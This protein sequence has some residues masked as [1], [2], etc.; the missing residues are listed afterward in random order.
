MHHPVSSDCAF[1]GISQ[2]SASWQGR[3]NSEE[4]IWK[5]DQ[6]V[7]VQ[8]SV[9]EKMEWPRY[10]LLSYGSPHRP[11]REAAN[12]YS[13]HAMVERLVNEVRHSIPKTVWHDMADE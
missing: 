1:S 10:F 12:S 7:A 3:S 9:D 8:L 6:R 4:N 5:C 11:A 2:A 13:D